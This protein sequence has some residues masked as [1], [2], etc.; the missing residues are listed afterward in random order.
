M[1]PPHNFQR[2]DTSAP[3]FQIEVGRTKEQPLPLGYTL[4]RRVNHN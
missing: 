3:P 2:G 1:R 4:T